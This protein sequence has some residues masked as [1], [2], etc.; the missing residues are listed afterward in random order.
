ML[1]LSLEA[2]YPNRAGATRPLEIT[3]YMIW[4]EVQLS[5]S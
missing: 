5:H 2:S 4:N 3:I 1:S